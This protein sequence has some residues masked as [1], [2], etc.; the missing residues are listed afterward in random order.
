M[1]ARI[2]GLGSRE[3]HDSGEHL[4]IMKPTKLVSY[5]SKIPI[6]SY[7]FSKG[8]AFIKHLLKQKRCFIN[9]MFTS[10]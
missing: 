1:N 6:I 10:A 4:E 2:K 7:D 5:F 9:N 8:K 3:G